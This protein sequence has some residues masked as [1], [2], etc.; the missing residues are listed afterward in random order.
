MNNV[1]VSVKD[2]NYLME[3]YDAKL[4]SANREIV[5][6]STLNKELNDELASYKSLV[7]QYESDKKEK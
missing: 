3:M 2:F 5:I 7:D 1:N 6:L 4:M